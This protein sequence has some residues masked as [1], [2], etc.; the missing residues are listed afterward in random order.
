M[1]TLENH[2]IINI[3]FETRVR[4]HNS[5]AYIPFGHFVWRAC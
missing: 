1:G 3:G 2:Q 5:W 4:N